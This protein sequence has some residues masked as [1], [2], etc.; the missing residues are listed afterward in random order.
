MSSVSGKN[1]LEND[2]VVVDTAQTTPKKPSQSK[3]AKASWT[4]WAGSYLWSTQPPKNTKKPPAPKKANPSKQPLKEKVVNILS[5]EEKYFEKNK[6]ALAREIAPFY[7][8]E[9]TLS[10]VQDFAQAAQLDPKE[11]LLDQVRGKKEEMVQAGE[12]SL[13]STM[14]GI[15][16]SVFAK[17]SSSMREA[18]QKT[19]NHFDSSNKYDDP[20]VYERTMINWSLKYNS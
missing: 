11:D 3:P 9:V 5:D 1:G 16:V 14:I 7:S 13:L 15:Y 10:V 6:G 4:S 19:L 20:I 12:K 2:W 17:D 8:G 18:I